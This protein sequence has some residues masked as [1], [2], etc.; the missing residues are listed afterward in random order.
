MLPGTPAYDAASMIAVIAILM[1]IYSRGTTGQGQ[2]I[3]TS[4]HESSRIG[5]FPWP[6]PGYSY[7][8]T[9]EGPPPTPETRLGV[10]Y[11]PIYPCK[12]GYIR[13]IAL[14]PRQWNALVRVLGNPEIL[15]LPDW[16]DFMYR[17][18]NAD[19]LYVL[20]IE[21]TMKYT[22]QELFEAGEREGVP[23]APIYDIAGFTNSP[24]TKAR[25]FFVEV[26]HPVAGR[27]PYPGPPYK[28]TETP[29]AIRRPAPCLGQHNERVYCEEL[30]LSKDDL[31]ALRCAG[32]L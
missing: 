1:A 10:S 17:L 31:S 3:D 26:D 7:A 21:L 30:G 20:M 8:L 24:Q 6:V 14:T 22:M 15:L 18:G 16:Q 5:L 25:E 32:V 11:A 12:D 19:D 13:V 4:V 28:W 9:E 27:A 23:I 29:A 2:H